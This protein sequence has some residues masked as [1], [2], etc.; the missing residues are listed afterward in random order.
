MSKYRIYLSPSNQF[1]NTYGYGDTNEGT[2]CTDIAQYC[3]TALERCGFEVMVAQ[4]NESMKIRCENSDNFKANLHVPLHTNAY[5]TN[6]MGTR[7]FYDTTGTPGY[8]AA[9]C[10]YDVLAPLT[11]GTSDALKAYPELYEVK[12][13]AAPTVY[14]E[15]EFH[16]APAGAKWIIEHKKDI[17]E[18]V[19]KGICNYFS[20]AYIPDK[21]STVTSPIKTPVL[22]KVAIH[23]PVLREGDCSETTKSLQQLLNAKGYNSGTPDKEYGPIT[24]NAVMEFQRM[25][26]IPVTGIVDRN[27][28]NRLFG[29]A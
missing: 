22:T 16:D 9:K 4:A 26:N 14:V 12:H 1:G 3:K 27:T 25:N 19:C 17:A 24:K 20:V 6:V 18:A 15:S 5:N 21:T 8:N 13:P 29:L 28:W 7:V 10:V 2:Q 23:M 11:P